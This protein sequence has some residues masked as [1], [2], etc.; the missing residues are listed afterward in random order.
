MFI[1]I[2]T[3]SS[4]TIV[5]SHEL[6]PLSLWKTLSVCSESHSYFHNLPPQLWGTVLE[7]LLVFKAL[8]QKRLELFIGL[9]DL[10]LDAAN[11]LLGQ[12][13][14]Q[15]LSF[16][17]YGIQ[18]ALPITDWV[19]DTLEVEVIEIPA[20]INE[21]LHY[22]AEP[23]EWSKREAKLRLLGKG[24]RRLDWEGSMW[25]IK[26]RLLT[27][28]AQGRTAIGTEKKLRAVN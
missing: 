25:L 20:I 2:E 26:L 4:S 3:Q 8:L 5:S 1:I 10:L 21:V 18:L 14:V 24:L 22:N 9:C 27:E 11:S 7:S 12:V 23:R 16:L 19:Q 28:A 15:S 17:S 6:F 13:C